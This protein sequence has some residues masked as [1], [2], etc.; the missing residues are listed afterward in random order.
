MQ[1]IEIAD[2]HFHARLVEHA[3]DA[4]T[5]AAGAAGDVGD[6]P[7]DV[8]DLRRLRRADIGSIRCRRVAGTDAADEAG[9]ARSR[10][11]TENL[12]PVQCLLV[13]TPP[14]NVAVVIPK[15]GSS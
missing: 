13:H 15:D 7:F 10:H 5:D 6:L 3:S 9:S 2:H 4:E 8:R 1:V 14:P 12:S 11:A